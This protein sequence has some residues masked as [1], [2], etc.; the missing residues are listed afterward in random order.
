MLK[1]D[2][3]HFY[4]HLQTFHSESSLNHY[5]R[6]LTRWAFYLDQH[7]VDV[8]DASPDDVTGFLRQL[9]DEYTPQTLGHVIS[10]IRALYQWGIDRER[11]G[12]NPWLSAR[13]P[14]EGRRLPN[15]VSQADMMR[16]LNALKPRLPR[17]MR[18]RAIL[19]FLYSTGC[20]VS[21]LCDAKLRHLS[22]ENGRCVV[23][24]K[25]NKDRICRLAP[26]TV[27]ELEGYIEVAR[28]YFLAGVEDDPGYIFLST[29]G[30]RICRS[31]VAEAIDRAKERAGL[32]ARITPHTLRHTF[33]THL[34]SN[35]AGI[36]QVKEMLGHAT[37]STTQLYLHLAQEDIDQ[38]YS[39]NH[40]LARQ[41]S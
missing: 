8:W 25:G 30:E 17:D 10:Y 12:R 1:G 37:I 39:A 18:D 34:L 5:R 13:R 4:R 6:W 40:P 33:A 41:G 19:H 23:T 36:L 27:E 9:R 21:E 11:T 3:S 31:R 35:G 38:A 16:L 22:L 14:R 28:P 7:G 24:G 20:R 32:T 29:H 2:F 26:A 15:I